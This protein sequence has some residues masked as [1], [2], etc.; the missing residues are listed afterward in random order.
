MESDLL[1]FVLGEG[2]PLLSREVVEH[3]E[4]DAGG[5][6][7]VKNLRLNNSLNPT[8]HSVPRNSIHTREGVRLHRAQPCLDVALMPDEGVFA[9]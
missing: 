9:V 8:A 6:S 4:G 1:G 2:G 7:N 3:G 5:L